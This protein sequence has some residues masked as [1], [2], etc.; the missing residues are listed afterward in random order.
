MA[1]TLAGWN[2]T[3]LT[4]NLSKLTTIKKNSLLQAPGQGVNCGC[5]IR[6]IN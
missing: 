4:V 3:L 2:L 1:S 6:N 5:W